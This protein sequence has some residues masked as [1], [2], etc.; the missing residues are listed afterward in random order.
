MRLLGI[1]SP[2][3]RMIFART[4]T[5]A[6]I[7][8]EL[9]M[10]FRMACSEDDRVRPEAGDHTGITIVS[11]GGVSQAWLHLFILQCSAR[12][13]ARI[14]ISLDVGHLGQ[15]R[16]TQADFPVLNQSTGK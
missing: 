3:F 4:R 11:H 1:P 6:G 10:A 2:A 9:E 8:S 16:R 15:S 7:S 13:R 14:P 5:R 12:R